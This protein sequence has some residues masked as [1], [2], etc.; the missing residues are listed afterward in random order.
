MSTGI[1]GSD[2]IV[3]KAIDAIGAEEILVDVQGDPSFGDR[4]PDQ[5]EQIDIMVRGDW[6]DAIPGD[7]Q[8]E[9]ISWS[10][11]DTDETK[12]FTDFVTFRSAVVPTTVSSAGAKRL[13]LQVIRTP[14]AGTPR[15]EEYASCVFK[16]TPNG[17]RPA[18]VQISATCY[19]RTEI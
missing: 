3:L 8:A 1:H 7:E 16:I 17:G 5:K 14:V 13:K 2:Q 15:T 10:A 4:M 19:G 9:E 18:T 12:I 6:V 11:L